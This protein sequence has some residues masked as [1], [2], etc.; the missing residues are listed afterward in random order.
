MIKR[1]FILYFIGN[2]FNLIAQKTVAYTGSIHLN[3]CANSKGFLFDYNGAPGLVNR[4]YNLARGSGIWLSATDSAGNIRLAAHNILG[5]QHDFWPGPMQIK[6]GVSADTSAWN[7]VYPISQGQI[8]YHQQHYKDNGYQVQADIL[9]WPGSLGSPY[10]QILAPFVDAK[11]NDLLYQPL[12]GDYPYIACDQ[13]VYTITNDNANAHTYSKAL[14]LGVEVHTSLYTFKTEDS[15]LANSILVRYVIHNRSGRNYK[16]FRLSAVTA[17]QIGSV[18]NEFLGTDI[19]NKTIFA[20]NDTMEATFKNKLVSLGCMAFNQNISSSIYFN[21]NSNVLNGRPS[22][23]SQFLNLM[24]GKWKSG[25]PLGYGGTGI[26]GTGNAKFVYPYTSDNS[27]GNLMWNE[28][29]NIPGKRIGLLNCDSTQLNNGAAKVYDFIFFN[30]EEKFNNIKQIGHFCL[31]LKQALDGKKLLD[32]P[33][34]NSAKTNKILVFPNPLSA[35]DKLFIKRNTDLPMIARI[36]D[37]N[38]KEINNY[39]LDVF[40]NCIILPANLEGGL[41]FIEFK[42]LNTIE[43]QILNIN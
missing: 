39:N 37:I 35:G 16:N 41:Y 23:D 21:D 19:D 24:Q 4:S 7:K 8:T 2:V 22:S 40:Q 18:E 30:V 13:L 28:Y 34:V 15:F 10:A 17:F 6:T 38:G 32:L 12:T 9:N 42:T 1:F 20:I 29:G 33:Q 11:V 14:P 36:V 5:G 25:K 31:N 26:D 3:G 27:N 43:R